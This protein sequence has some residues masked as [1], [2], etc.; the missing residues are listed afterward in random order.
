MLV[1][2]L[3]NAW[4]KERTRALASVPLPLLAAV[5]RTGTLQQRQRPG[6]NVTPSR[7]WQL[8]PILCAHHTFVWFASVDKFLN[9]VINETTGNQAKHDGTVQNATASNYMNG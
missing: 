1:H 7:R 5:T 9:S 3:S 2:E 4:M 6:A 8:A